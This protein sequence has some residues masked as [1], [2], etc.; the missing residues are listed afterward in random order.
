MGYLIM[1]LKYA[2]EVVDLGDEFIAVPVGEGANNL[3]GVIKMNK[4]GKEIVDMLMENMSFDEIVQSLTNRYQDSQDIIVSYVSKTIE[5][6]DGK[7][8]LIE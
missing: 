1:K 5:V 6:L 8:L 3:N 7:G 2:L 4:T